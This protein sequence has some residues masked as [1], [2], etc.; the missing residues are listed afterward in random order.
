MSVRLCGMLVAVACC[1][2]FTGCGGGGGSQSAP[3]VPGAVQAPSATMPAATAA[4]T[5]AGSGNTASSALAFHPETSPAGATVT[6]GASP[7]AR[8]TQSLGSG[9]S[10]CAAPYPVPIVNPFPFAI[11]LDGNDFKLLFALLPPLTSC[12]VTG[13]NF[14]VALY[15]SNPLQTD[16]TTVG[17]LTGKGHRL[18]GFVPRSGVTYTLAANTTTT[19]LFAPGG[20]GANAIPVLPNGTGTGDSSL[21]NNIGNTA[22]TGLGIGYSSASTQGASALSVT[23]FP[24]TDP[25]FA[26]AGLNNV[27]FPGKAKG[28]CLFGTGSGSVTL[29]ST[30]T[31]TITNPD[32]D[33]SFAEFDGSTIYAPCTNTAS[34]KCTTSVPVTLSTS[35]TG[36][37]D[38]ALIFGNQQDLDACVPKNA[39]LECRPSATGAP[40]PNATV[41]P[42]S[43]E[44]DVLLS[45]DPAYTF[46]NFQTF[47]LPFLGYNVSTSGGCELNLNA[48]RNSDD[49]PGYG[50]PDYRD[51]SDRGSGGVY[52]SATFPMTTS[53]VVNNSTV[54][55]KATSDIEVDLNAVHGAG[56]CV[57][58]LAEL[59]SPQHKLV[60]DLTTQTVV[61]YP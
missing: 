42:S 33:L 51:T 1:L 61:S 37:T 18:N 48:D 20:A 36:N 47:G 4:T 25:R 44:Y 22:G 53:Y 19:L 6:V 17:D 50:D 11:T 39:E 57:I 14:N 40:S 58:T 35:G 52:W 38:R 27:Y 46:D 13:I 9:G 12:D 2:A 10:N 56:D 59:S 5:T 30:V 54:N 7:A 43:G 23:C 32:P 21:S 8:S 34:P 15:Q 31:I 49:P 16:A 26:A 60:K 55:L 28:A 45:N 3:V 41:A 29:G 24:D